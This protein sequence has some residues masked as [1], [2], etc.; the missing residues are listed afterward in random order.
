MKPILWFGIIVLYTVLTIL[1]V[2]LIPVDSIFSWVTYFLGFT[3][4]TIMPGYCLI[5]VLFEEGKLELIESAV[6]S[7]ALS[8]S[9][10]GVSGLFLGLSPIGLAVDSIIFTLSVIVLILAVLSFIRKRS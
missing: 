10:V 2:Y 5:N 8:F 1:A 9:L 6:L 4:V 3:F 7:V